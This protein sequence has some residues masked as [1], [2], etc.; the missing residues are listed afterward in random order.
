M[1]TRLLMY[2]HD[3]SIKQDAEKT[4]NIK[5]MCTTLSPEKDETLAQ[6]VKDFFRWSPNGNLEFQ[7]V[8]PKA[9]EQF[10]IGKYYYVTLEQREI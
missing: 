1:A 7:T 2:C 10:E 6:E 9:A 3:K 5:L 4:A 8:N